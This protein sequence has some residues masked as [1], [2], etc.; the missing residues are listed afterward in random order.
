MKKHM[1]IEH[2]SI[3]G[4]RTAMRSIIWKAFWMLVTSVVIR[5][6]RPAVENLSMLEKEK[7]CTLQYMASRR[8]Q[9]KPVDARAEKRP[10]A[11]PKQRLHK[12]SA[13]ISA[14]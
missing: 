6:T 2:S 5:V 1:N 9:A 11:T 8:L 7:V 10:A 14:P 4:A 13:S 3:S 12:A